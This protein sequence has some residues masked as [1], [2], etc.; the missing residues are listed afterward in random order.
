MTKQAFDVSIEVDET[1]GEV[2]AVYFQFRKGESKE[3]REY[4][5]GDVFADFNAKGELLGIEM[6]APCSI[7]V[8]DKIVSE[9]ESQQF[10]RRSIP[11]EMALA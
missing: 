6:L 4:H 5:D 11:R 3:V 8:L 9:S 1:T 2:A 10:I 7:A